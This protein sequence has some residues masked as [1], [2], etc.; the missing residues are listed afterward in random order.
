MDFTLNKYKE[1]C[2]KATKSGYEIITV[3]DYLTDLNRNKVIVMRHDVDRFLNKALRMS[4]LEHSLG[5]RTTYYFRKS[6]FKR[7][8]IIRSI[9]GMG[10]EIGFHYEVLDEAHGDYEDAITLF[11]EEIADLRKLAKVETVCMHGN[12][13][14]KWVNNSIWEKCDFQQFNVVGEAY[15]SF[16]DIHYFS[17]TGRIWDM[18]RKVKDIMP[19]ASSGGTSDIA[20]ILTTDDLIGFVESLKSPQIYITVHPERWSHNLIGWFADLSRD[21]GTNA[22]KRIWRVVRAA[23]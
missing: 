9:A 2:Q 12:P 10:H 3:S 20:N 16:K 1:L 6:G 19:R 8:D 22:V 13:L 4:Q 7:Q 5:I 14:T 21:T 18:S 23:R 17:D 11:K 15:L